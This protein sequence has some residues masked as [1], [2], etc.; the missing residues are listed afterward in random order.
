[1]FIKIGERINSSRETIARALST[2]DEAFIRREARLQKE[3]GAHMLDVNCAFNTKNEPSDM[4]WLVS[5]VQDETGLPLSI[6][7]PNPDAI[8]AG[9]RKHKGKALINSITLEKDRADAILPLV[10][11][12]KASVIVLAMDGKAMPHNAAGRLDMA[13]N[14]VSLLAAHGVEKDDLYIDPLVRP[15]SSEPDQ[16]L[17]VIKSVGLIKSATGAKLTCGLSNIS[18]GLP[19]RS[20]LNA[21]FLAMM[22][23]AGLDAAILDP[24]NKK[25]NAILRASSA[26][27]GEDEFCMEYIKSHREGELSF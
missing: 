26:L 16:A 11:K 5:L 13:K 21:V 9:L 27:L 4:E 17:E 8:E 23:S 3:A 18:F 6:D 22:L 7:S 1:M 20:M 24:L 15:I 10:K 12:Y 2:K 19:D 25:I 14:A